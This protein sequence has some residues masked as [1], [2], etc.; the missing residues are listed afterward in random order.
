V[1]DTGTRTHALQLARADLRAGSQAV[2]VFQRPLKDPRENFHIAV[3]VLAESLPRRDA[4]FV[5]DA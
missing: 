2:F 5:D 3:R 4:V 1:S